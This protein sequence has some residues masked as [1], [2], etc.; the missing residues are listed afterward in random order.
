MTLRL[1]NTLAGT[2]EVFEPLEPGRVRMYTCGPTVHDL[3][4]VG[5]FRTFLFEDVLRRYL[6]YSGYAV[7]Q[8]MNITDVD[9]KIILKAKAAGRS[10]GE[11]TAE[12]TRLFFE[13]ARTLGI[14]PAEHYPRA[15][16]YVPEMVRLILRLRELGHTYER[17][18]SVYFRIASFTRYGK[19]SGIDLS[20]CVDGARVDSDEYGKEDPKDFVLW[21]AAKPGEHYW[22]SPLGPG[23]PG[24]HI[25]CSAMA[26]VLL[27]ESFDIHTGGVDNIFPHHE[28]EIAQSESATRKPFAR[29]WLHAQ[30]L[31][32]ADRKMAKS[33]GNFLT[34]RELLDRGHDPL[35]VRYLLI[36]PHYRS[37]L[38][39]GEEG[40]ANAAGARERLRDFVGRLGQLALEGGEASPGP[41]AYLESI[42]AGERRASE[43]ELLIA[44]SERVFRD[45]LDDDLNMP[46]AL[47]AIF[48][49]VRD[50]NTLLDKGLTSIEAT[51]LWDCFYSWNNV[52]GAFPSEP[53]IA[54]HVARAAS[55]PVEGDLLAGQLGE[56]IAQL[57]RERGEARLRRDFARSDE[58]RQALLERGFTVEDTPA[59]Q[60]VKTVR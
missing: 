41:G 56:E 21:K 43:A 19:L 4:H 32:I 47:A 60:R 13:D 40:L 31:V 39:F 36:A 22:D 12:Y 7:T 45:A 59:G 33:L 3:I 17:D 8:V 18:G 49:F 6:E 5:N 58:L 20:G 26:M 52:L 14:E 30:H 29:Y 53:R 1:Y 44:R 11:Y 51:A 55:V 35:A 15:T 37:P 57:L 2:K 25:E 16:D 24:W 42:Q 54:H 46:Q 38:Q 9:D 34:L 50:G 27:G 23:R 10:I 48:S 28:N